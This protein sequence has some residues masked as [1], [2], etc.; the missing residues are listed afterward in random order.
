[1]FYWKKYWQR[2]DVSEFL[3]S[4]AFFFLCVIKYKEVAIKWIDRFDSKQISLSH[5]A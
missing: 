3:I 2:P 5:Y 1:M 4:I